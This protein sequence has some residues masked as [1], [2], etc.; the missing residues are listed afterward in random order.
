MNCSTLLASY[1]LPTLGKF[2]YC[3]WFKCQISVKITTKIF[4]LNRKYKF[5]DFVE[6][7]LK[8]KNNLN[9]WYFKFFIK[10]CSKRKIYESVFKRVY[11]NFATKKKEQRGLSAAKMYVYNF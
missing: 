1:A 11:K 5:F 6:Q 10:D 4:F 7:T 2:Y 8:L 3:G 9:F